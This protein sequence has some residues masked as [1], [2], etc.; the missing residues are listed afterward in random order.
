MSASL[1]TLLF[2]ICLCEA[3]DLL[4]IPRQ[5]HRSLSM[6]PMRALGTVTVFASMLSVSCSPSIAMIA[7]GV[8]ALAVMVGS[9][10]KYGILGE[11]LVFSDLVVARSFVLYPRFYISLIPVGLKVAVPAV[12]LLTLWGF[13]FYY[14]FDV[15]QLLLG[16]SLL[17]GSLFAL[18]LISRHAIVTG[19]MRRPDLE[20][21]IS[22][23]GMAPV[24]LIYW[25][26]WLTG[27]ARSPASPVLRV[28]N[29]SPPRC[30]VIIQ[31][32]SFAEIPDSNSPYAG[33]KQAREKAIAWGDL[34]VSGFGAYTMRTEYGVLTGL[35]EETLGFDAFDPF[36]HAE[37]DLDHA[38]PRKLSHIYPNAVFV[39]PHD[40]RFY[41]RDR[42]MPRLGFTSMIGESEFTAPPELMPYTTDAS[43]GDKIVSLIK[44]S[45]APTLIYAVSMENH[46]P[47]ADGRAGQQSGAASWMFHAQRSDLL[48]ATLSETFASLDDDI[49]LVFFGDHRPSIPGYCEPG[50]EKHTPYVALRFDGPSGHAGPK[51][52][53]PKARTPAELHH[54]IIGIISGTYPDA[55]RTER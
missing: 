55:R 20:G 39:H 38:L 7:T 28:S 14:R 54:L 12:L 35:D 5:R 13:C 50:T 23:F 33:L 53:V 51:V 36:L 25:Q 29:T 24:L 46:G 47:W 16:I 44:S 17:F 41:G 10:I 48:L 22:A 4:T 52:R 34:S 6:L 18:R 15:E 3:V 31:C 21:D 8:L 30:T 9:N 11:P 32:E 42:L 19:I 2:T 37:Q 43:L 45:T 40:L 27:R 1:V 26:R 49:L